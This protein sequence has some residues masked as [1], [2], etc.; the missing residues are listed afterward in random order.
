MYQQH[1]RIQGQLNGKTGFF[2]LAYTELY[3]PASAG[4]AGD[5]ILSDEAIPN[6]EE[7]TDI[8]RFSDDEH[9]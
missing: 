1:S 5:S 3:D 8:I 9:I 2:P 6:V 7:V 4:S